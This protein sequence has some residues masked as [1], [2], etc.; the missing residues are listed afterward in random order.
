MEWSY[1]MHFLSLLFVS[2]VIAFSVSTFADDSQ[3]PEDLNVP[4]SDE[5][6]LDQYGDT[7]KPDTRQEQINEAKDQQSHVALESEVNNMEG[8]T[9][10]VSREAVAK[11][12]ASYTDFLSTSQ[13]PPPAVEKPQKSSTYEIPALKKKVAEQRRLERLKKAGKYRSAKSFAAHK[14]KK[15]IKYA[16]RKNSKVKQNK[17][18]KHAKFAKNG[19]KSKRKLA[20]NR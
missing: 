9:V 18:G 2:V 7:V 8:P 15:H 16:N 1:K 6:M 10:Q 13:P 4:E 12:D 17:A 5:A 20:V 3:S 19:V 11:E 14:N